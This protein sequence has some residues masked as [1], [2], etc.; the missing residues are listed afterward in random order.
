MDSPSI[1]PWVVPTTILVL[2]TTEMQ[3]ALCPEGTFE[4]DT[5]AS[6][7]LWGLKGMGTSV[8]FPGNSAGLR[9]GA[10]GML[11][12][13][14]AVVVCLG[15]DGGT[16]C[17]LITGGFTGEDGGRLGLVEGAGAT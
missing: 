3:L 2:S 8:L 10:D 17:R 7:N 12:E 4:L 1:V 14:F 13:L 15:E 16:G 9:V 5:N 11:G 6:L